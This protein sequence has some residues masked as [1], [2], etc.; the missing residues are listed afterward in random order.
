M[1]NCQL[2]ILLIKSLT[3]VAFLLTESVYS[4][5]SYTNNN[6]VTNQLLSAENFINNGNFHIDIEGEADYNFFNLKKFVN[7]GLFR[8]NQNLVL[9]NSETNEDG[10]STD[11]I[12]LELF[13]NQ[14]GGVVDVN[15]TEREFGY[16][17]IS[18]DQISNQG[19]LVA[20]NSNSILLKG[21]DVDL[22]RGIVNVKSG[23]D[24]EAGL[25][26]TGQPKNLGFLGSYYNKRN[27]IVP[28]WMPDWG[29][30]DVYWGVGQ[31]G[32]SHPV[33]NFE[34]FCQSYPLFTP[35]PYPGIGAGGDD[36]S[37]SIIT[38]GFRAI[39]LLGP[40]NLIYNN[41]DLYE[42]PMRPVKPP[43]D[44][45]GAYIEW[46]IA[47]ISGFTRRTDRQGQKFRPYIDY[48]RTGSGDSQTLYAQG[49]FVMNRNNAVTI[50]PKFADNDGGAMT[51][52][53]P[54]FDTA[55][56]ELKTSVTNRI[57]E[58]MDTST[59]YV[60]SELGSVRGAGTEMQNVQ[61]TVD[62]GTA[63]PNTIVVTRNAN[64]EFKEAHSPTDSII[65]YP[66]YGKF[67]VGYTPQ[68]N[69]NWTT[70][71]FRYT[72]VLSRLN[73]TTETSIDIEG[74]V[75]S[76]G[77][78]ISQTEP[79]SVVIDAGNLN[80]E[81]A[82]IRAEGMLKIKAE[83][84]ISSKNA[85]LD[86]QNLSLD[87]GSKGRLLLIEDLVPDEVY[88]FG[89]SMELWEGTWSTTWKECDLVLD[90][91]GF[92]E[93]DENGNLRFEEKTRPFHYK[94]LVIDTDSS[95]TNKVHVQSLKLKGDDVIIRDKIRLQGE[96]VFDA[97][98][99]TF[100]NDFLVI[101][102]PGDVFKWDKTV[103]SG[104]NAIT[105]N[106]V[107]TLPGDVQMG[108]IKNR[109]KNY[110][111]SGTN[112]TENLEIIS[113]NFNNTGL[114]SV[115]GSLG[116]DSNYSSLNNSI[117]NVDENFVA[118]GNYLK[119]RNSTNHIGGILTF[120]IANT[121]IDGG[122]N[123]TNLFRVQKGLVSS[124]DSTKGKLLHSEFRL[125]AGSYKS[126]PF[127]WNSSEDK[128]PVAGG[129]EN[130]RAIGLL[131]LTNAYLGVFEINSTSEGKRAL[132]VDKLVLEGVT[133]KSLLT[134]KLDQLKIEDDLT[135]YF[136]GS[137][138]PEE[139]LDGMRGGRLKWVKEFAGRYSS[140]P[141]YMHGLSRSVSVNRA[142]RRSEIFD[143]D[144]D[145]VANGFDPTPFGSGRPTL[146]IKGD[147]IEW[148]GVPHATYQL[149]FTRKL[150]KDQKWQK[151]TVIKNSNLFKSL[152]YKIPRSVIL[153]T[154]SAGNTY[155]RVADLNRQ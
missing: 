101:P 21:K 131:S 32:I 58:T 152:S 113:E 135:V 40:K 149:E 129:F 154:G 95:M 66:F 10:D 44:G 39:E 138:L 45:F 67:G 36:L 150:G 19:T 7:A 62:G 137:N 106:A 123:S 98:S 30:L 29:V 75:D 146:K 99:V 63:S 90:D 37:V 145:G 43:I 114:I 147:M 61:P 91:N 155:V 8:F 121:M 55:V 100:D 15:R 88:R 153:P 125:S 117:L 64:M 60:M 92:P 18:A 85:I 35:E 80:L 148:L 104:V 72:N 49:V 41:Y 20:T 102:A 47:G 86:C 57:E 84:L 108:T 23:A 82:K 3:L 33:R 68:Y 122:L 124:S 24:Y 12:P 56:V 94:M 53:R 78:K 22:S 70:Y 13:N 16:F 130:N 142:Y 46:N 132:Y 107:L 11:T 139:K 140:M 136:A 52:G 17:A 143:T 111:N 71:G 133:E 31:T 93:L 51:G 105:N 25:D 79:G 48:F 54:A 112:K 26:N 115:N 73:V 14:V 118:K 5:S 97:R 120:D 42:E 4:Q 87:I 1:N 127:T 2:R 134:N 38:G 116:L 9:E 27:Y 76:S 59:I 103:A 81:A 65:D 74:N 126:F 77:Q 141:L 83:N 110:T 69:V 50:T 119:L 28:A 89:G 151:L 96:L 6:S 128:G 34:N 109:Y 144:N